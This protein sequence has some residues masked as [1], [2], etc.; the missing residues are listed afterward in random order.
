M[1]KL[2]R[3]PVLFMANGE[4]QTEAHLTDQQINQVTDYI[5]AMQQV[6]DLEEKTA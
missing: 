6:N 3:W 1:N 4:W 2:K 5:N